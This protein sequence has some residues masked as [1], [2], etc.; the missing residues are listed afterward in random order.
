MI[1]FLLDLVYCTQLLEKAKAE[2]NNNNIVEQEM[3]SDFNE[4]CNGMYVYVISVLSKIYNSGHWQHSRLLS[5]F[6]LM[7]MEKK[8]NKHNVD[9]CQVNAYNYKSGIVLHVPV[10]IFL[11]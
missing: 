3:Q 7:K 1:S 8:G 10:F 9:T 6:F 11:K 5:F 4:A 2:E